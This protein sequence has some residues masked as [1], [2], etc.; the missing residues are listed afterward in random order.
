MLKGKE[1]LVKW[2][3]E[4]TKTADLGDARLNRRLGN[5]LDMLSRQPKESIPATLKSWNETKSAYRFFDH[6]EVTDQTVI[7]PH[8][9]ATIERMRQEPVILLPQDTTELDFSKMQGT[10]GL[11]RLS[12]PFQ[13]GMYLHPTVAITPDRVCL[14]IVD[15]QVI[16]RDQ[17]KNENMLPIILL[18]VSRNPCYEALCLYLYLIKSIKKPTKESISIEKKESMRWLNSYRKAQALA[19]Q[20]PESTIVSI[21]DREGD[22]YDIFMEAQ[23]QTSQAEFI[24]RGNYDRRLMNEEKKLKSKILTAPVKGIVEFELPKL[25]NRKARQVTQEIRAIT[26]KLSPPKRVGKKLPAIFIN[27]VLAREINAPDDIEPIEWMLLT[28]LPIE[29]GEQALQVIDWYLCRWQVEILFKVLKSGCEIEELQLKTAERLKPCIA[30]YM[31]IAWR[32][33]YLTMLGRSCPNIPCNIVFENEEWHAVYRVIYRKPPPEIPPDLN[34]MIR[35]IA[36]LGGFLNR[37]SDGSPGPKPIWIGLQRT[38]DFV[39]AMEALNASRW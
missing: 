4:E 15:L 23:H 36:S 13:Q 33:L 35:M 6:P 18:C 28:S 12:Y 25:K 21:A 31:I 14:G 1:S 34:T 38:R 29:T 19:K 22:I 8:V 26:V 10:T 39:I 5:V 17:P 24:I 37:K 7:L 11:G 32:I 27:V 16:I 9:N 30:L 3:N 2:A 20:L